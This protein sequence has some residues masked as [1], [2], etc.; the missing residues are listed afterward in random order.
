MQ[1]DTKDKVKQCVTVITQ[2][3]HNINKNNI[4]IGV[5]EGLNS[6]VDSNIIIADIVHVLAYYK[7]EFMQ[8]SAR[9][10]VIPG[11]LATSGFIRTSQ[12]C[13]RHTSQCVYK[14]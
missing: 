6:P 8:L 14:Q 4:V 7:W 3:V 2:W 9:W 11:L 1:S 5:D 12:S 10:Q 13:L